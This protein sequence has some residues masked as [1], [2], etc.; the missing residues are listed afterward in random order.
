MEMK[1]QTPET[2]PWSLRVRDGQ[3]VNA[4]QIKEKFSLRV[5]TR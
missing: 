3:W 4:V 1:I 5:A 2:L